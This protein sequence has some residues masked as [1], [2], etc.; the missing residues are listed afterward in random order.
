[1]SP[2][3]P[4]PP[5]VALTGLLAA[6]LACGQLGG[7]AGATQPP[8]GTSEPAATAT[9]GGESPTLAATQAGS[10]PAPDAT[11]TTQSEAPTAAATE[12][13]TEVPATEAPEV[14]LYPIIQ[15]GKYGFMDEAGQVVIP[16]QFD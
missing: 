15:G 7:Q 14:R 16:A 9:G 5:L 2:I 1:M 6:A 4:R 3:L 10:E 11:E 12:P 8:A 13:P